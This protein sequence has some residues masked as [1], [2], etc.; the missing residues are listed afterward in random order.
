MGGI[1][2]IINKNRHTI[3]HITT[4]IM[5]NNSVFDEVFE[6]TGKGCVVPKDV[7]SVRF[8]PSVVEVEDRAFCDCNKL[9][10]IV[11]NEGLKKIEWN[12]FYGCK[13]L[14]SV[15]LPSTVTEI[16]SYAFQYCKQLR[17]VVFHEGL[18]KI[19]AGAFNNCTLLSSITLPSTVTEID[20]CA[21]TIVAI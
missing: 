9:R 19:G 15:T 8:H 5:S 6:Y 1:L 21:F 13:S 17:E 10:E 16:G 20:R 18:Q 3:L 2:Y 12:A 11:F 14:E 4:N 7:T